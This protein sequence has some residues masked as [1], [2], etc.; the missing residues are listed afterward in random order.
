MQVIMMA[1]MF[2]VQT[3]AKPISFASVKDIRLL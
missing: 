3:E 1:F 2:Q